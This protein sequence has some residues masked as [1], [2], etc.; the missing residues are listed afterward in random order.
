MDEFLDIEKN[1]GSVKSIIGLQFQEENMAIDSKDVE[2]EEFEKKEAVEVPKDEDGNPIPP[3]EGQKAAFNPSDYKWTK[4]NCT[5]R[6]LPQIF[7]GTKG[8][9]AVHEVKSA[10]QFSANS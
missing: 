3:P 10:E 5:P 7:M 2:Y 9:E 1:I 4:I 6:N 8:S